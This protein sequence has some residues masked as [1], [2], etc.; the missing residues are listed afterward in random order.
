MSE[1]VSSSPELNADANAAYEKVLPEAL[2]LN[3]DL[4]NVINV[5]IPSAIIT[6]FGVCERLPAHT[7]QLEALP[8]FPPERLEKLQDYVMALFIAQARY[9]TATTPTEQLARLLDEATNRRDIMTA[10]ART[11]IVRGLL[12]SNAL[13]DLTGTHGYKNVAFDLSRLAQL[14]KAA[15]ASIQGKTG[16]SAAEIDEADRFALKLT[17]AIA[18]REGSPQSAAEATN[19]RQ[20]M[21]T[22][23]LNTYDQIRR[24]MVFLRWN[25]GDADEIAPSLYANRAVR[26]QKKGPSEAPATSD[27]P[28]VP[29]ATTPAA[30]TAAG[31]NTHDS[32]VPVGF[33]GSS[34]LSAS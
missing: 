3:A 4:L 24:A 17:L 23:F 32:K 9:T 22:L 33:P 16:L 21:F 30:S 14:F 26:T 6:G 8:D 28:P 5:D 2:A 15:L 20:R 34:P 11:L 19:V 13:D 18:H 12:P 25:I 10:E 27:K 7:K 1:S 31:S 29:A